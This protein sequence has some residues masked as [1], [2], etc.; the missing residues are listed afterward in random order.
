M[1]W[2]FLTILW[3]CCCQKELKHDNL[4]ITYWSSNNTYEI[5]F[6][7]VMVR[8]WNKNHPEV[9]VKLQPVPEGR[10]SE[11]VILAAVV[12]KTTPDIYSNMWQGDV[13]A[14]ARAGVLVPLDT[15][16]GF[17]EFL[18]QRCDSLVVEEVT[19][20]DGHI[21]QVP[22]KINPIM[23]IYNVKWFKE[24]G[25]D[26]PPTTYSEF[27]DAAKKIRKDTDGDG[28]VDKWIG[29]TEV[30]VTWWQRLFDFY[31]LYLAASD[32]AP[33]VQNRKIVFNNKYAVEV[34]RFLKT[35]FE[36]KFF[37]RERL[38]ARQDP[39][40]SSAIATRFTG[41]WEI[42][43][44]EHFKPKDFQ[45]AF[46][47]LPTPDKASEHP[48]T[49]ADPKNI[50]IFNTCKNP[51]N[52]FEFL[53]FMLSKEND[54][55]FLEMTRQI[56][57]RKD[58]LTDGLFQ[59]FLQK[60]EQLFTFAKQSRY[61]RGTDNCPVLKEIFDVISQEFEA[62]VVYGTK[63]PEKAIEDAASAAQVILK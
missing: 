16:P 28:Y 38:S 26:Q 15:I 46:A 33:L 30:L 31:P 5:E 39:F 27:L 24:I 60:N 3:L 45:Y 19:A 18:Y 32:G 51:K 62:C 23:M 12:G 2:V 1:K 37:P 40:L 47:P 14:Y 53:K 42:I 29:Y 35:L 13:E 17:L 63:S 9:P 21:Y 7:K 55:R 50:V 48:Y 10:S 58:L 43:H 11:E 8:D 25:L 44:A 49:Y 56:P 61:V 34:F 6:A 57:R 36:E 20:L 4:Q 59:E 52:A 54:F 41:P 22:W